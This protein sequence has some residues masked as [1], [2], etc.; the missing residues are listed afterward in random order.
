MLAEHWSKAQEQGTQVL[1]KLRD[2]VQHSEHLADSSGILNVST[3][4]KTRI[5]GTPGFGI[6][7]SLLRL[8]IVCFFSVLLKT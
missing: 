1:D 5:R 8:S 4:S 6:L 7:W 3:G 2:G